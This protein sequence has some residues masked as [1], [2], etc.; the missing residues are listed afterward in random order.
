[1]TSVHEGQRQD[2]N[3]HISAQRNRGACSF[4]EQ[5]SRLPPCGGLAITHRRT[6]GAGATVSTDSQ[7]VNSR[8]GVPSSKSAQAQDLIQQALINGPRSAAEILAV[9]EGAKIARRTLQLAASRIGV[10]RTKAGIGGGWTWA[11]PASDGEVLARAADLKDGNVSVR[12]EP[13]PI[14]ERAKAIAAM[15]NRM[16]ERRT[17]SRCR[18]YWQDPRVQAWAAKGA[19]DFHIR[20]ARELAISDSDFP[21]ILTA[22]M[23]DRHLY[24]VLADEGAIVECQ[25]AVQ[26]SK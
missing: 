6:T 12:A 19:R 3:L 16:E 5:G 23:I 26:L 13:S 21:G 25:P 18:V 1:M 22:G 4:G 9:A 17:G 10:K 2:S 11:L 20:E 14:I 8:P 7:P 24:T 15:L